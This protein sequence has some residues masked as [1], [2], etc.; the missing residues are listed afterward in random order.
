M[1]AMARGCLLNLARAI[2]T[3][4]LLLPCI[5]CALYFIER[6][7]VLLV[8]LTVTAVIMQDEGITSSLQ[9]S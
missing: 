2:S 5:L 9:S 3:A 8:Y 4:V 6:E 1:K 7:R